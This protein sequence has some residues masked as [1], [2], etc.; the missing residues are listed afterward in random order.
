MQIKEIVKLSWKT[1]SSSRLRTGITICIIALGIFALILFLTTLKA[2]S[3]SLTDSFSSMGANAFSIRFK[4]RFVNFGKRNSRVSKA[5][6]NIRKERK[7]NAGKVITYE[8]AMEFKERYKFP[9]LVGVAIRGTSGIVVNTNKIKTNPEINVFGG[10]EN[11][12][13]L[14]GYKIA[15]GRNIVASDLQSDANICLIG[16]SVAEL[17]FAG[18]PAKAVDKAVSVDQRPFRVIGVLEEKSASAFFNPNKMVVTTLNCIR[19]YYAN[20]STS[21]AIAVKVNDIKYLEAAIG[22]AT[23]TFRP[24]RKLDI[25]DEENFYIDKSDSAAASLIKNLG[26]VENGIIGVALI[27]LLASSIGL[28]NIMLVSVNERTKEIGLIK[29]L[30][31]KRSDILYQFLFESILISIL[32]AVVG[33]ILGV[34]IGNLVGI[35]LNSGLVLL[36]NYIFLGILICFLVGVVAGLYPALKAS[37]LDPIVALRYE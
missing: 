36:W 17:L 22:E 24:L 29:A 32:G 18:N 11:Y 23:G 31:G 37:K 19:N 33:I 2:A 5:N 20:Q 10:D 1:I 8:Q 28:T 35:A 13:E 26:F 27:T 30:G 25:K 15:H 12:V 21:Y 6:K 14:N 7:S 16:S 3:S 34:I 9:A 4:E